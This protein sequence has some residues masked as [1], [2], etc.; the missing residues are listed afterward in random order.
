DLLERVY[1]G[2]IG[3]EH[4]YLLNDVERTW[5]QDRLEADSSEISEKERLR[6]FEKLYRAEYFEKFLAKK[7]VG[8]KR[9]SIEGGETTIP[10]I[11]TLI[12]EGSQDGIEHVVI[13][14]AHRGRLS[15][16]VNT[17]QKPASQIFAEFEENAD[18]E[19]FPNSDVKYHMGYSNT[20]KTTGGKDV[21]L[22]LMFNPS[23]L[24]AVNPVA[25]GSV[26][27]RQTNSGD[28]NRDRHIGLLI[29]GDAAFP[30]QGVVPET[31]NLM[32]LEGFDTGGTIH[33]VINNQIGFTTRPHESRSTPYATDLA[34]GFQVPIFHVNGD[35]PEAAHRVMKL[36]IE[37]RQKF[38]KD[39][40][41]DL[42][43]YRRL[44]HN[45]TDEPAFTQPIMY[46]N[47]RKRPTTVT[48]YQK[49]LVDSGIDDSKLE[50]IRKNVE[51]SLEVS[52]QETHENDVKIKIDTMGGV[53]SGFSTEKLDSEPATRLLREQ[54]IRVADALAT[55][56]AGFTP[57][58]KLQKLIESRT[59]MFEGKQPIDWGMAEALAF[60]S[61]LESGHRIR[62]CGQDAKRGTFSH[63]HA[64]LV[65]V[66]TEDRWVPL[67][68]I[69][70]NQGYFEIINSSLS[71]FSVLGFEYGYSLSSPNDL[72]IW[73]AQFGDFANGAQVMIDQFL[74]SSEVKWRRMSGLTLLLPHGYEGQGPE[75]SSARIERFLQLCAKNN[76]LVCNCTTPAQYFHL[77]RRQILRRFRKPLIVMTP[78]SLLR[79]PAAVSTVEDLSEGVF[80]EVL[81]DKEADPRKVERVLFCSG[82]VY[83]DLETG[84]K[85]RNA[86]D[87]AIVR[88]EQLYPFDYN[89]VRYVIDSY[90]KLKEI[91]W[92]QEE[93]R[94]MGPWFFARDRFDKV[95]K[96]HKS[97]PLYVVA[98][99]TSPSPAAGLAKVHQLEQKN[100]VERAF[101]KDTSVFT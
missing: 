10:M 66:N 99:P 53:W 13:A 11:D 91:V 19:S 56:P 101:S 95:F 20:V 36:A 73:E 97:V 40:I 12:E 45:E 60:G 85:E 37:Y 75:H 3:S 14:M 46:E 54:M 62:L 77:L 44:G 67:N 65:D 98:R 57:H 100:I 30:G 83:Y 35:D 22:T 47:I 2:T 59:A 87:V 34:K 41:I 90:P 18:A 61:I 21:K 42:I 1:C 31:L 15:V 6:L 5:I 17:I 82:K 25:L 84:R 55:V 49:H 28:V 48:L 86:E 7:Y 64:E 72:V 51:N 50:S 29:H 78:K 79:H 27:A 94:N 81:Y 96:N 43:C 70:E 68:H 71:E 74:S 26:R 80:F 52:F 63:R 58:P 8:K 24:E 23:H 89:Q 33:I 88:M 9:F 38:H 39:V 4:Y 69:S 93:P 32:N 92:V 16:L 76:M